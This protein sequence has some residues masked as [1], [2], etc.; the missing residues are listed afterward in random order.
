MHDVLAAIDAG[1]QLRQLARAI[2]RVE[3]LHRTADDVVARVAEQPFRAGIPADDGAVQRSCR[4]SPRR[5]SPTIAA[6]RRRASSAWC[7]V[8]PSAII[9]GDRRQS[10]GD[11]VRERA[12][13]EQRHRVRRRGPRPRAA[14]RR[15]VSGSRG[16]GVRD[17]R[18]RW[19]RASS[20]PVAGWVST[21]LDHR[22]I[23]V[24]DD[25]F[26]AALHRAAQIAQPVERG[27]DFG[28]HRGERGALG[29]RGFGAGPDGNVL[30][31]D[32]DRR[33][34]REH[35]RVRRDLHVDESRPTSDGAASRSDRDI[36]RA[37]RPE[38]RQQRRHLVGGTDV[39][40]A[41]REELA[42]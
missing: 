15:L 7:R 8:T 18:R 4:K 35:Q 37:R 11:A 36:G 29:Q 17:G 9:A 34:A 39:G 20:A 12:A 31:R 2:G 41:H 42:P 27:A 38:R 23:E 30:R 16:V 1:H 21:D 32:Q 33:P 6:S 40:D 13:R 5:S 10:G 3:Q 24:R 19:R 14:T 25:R 26:G 22:E 28:R